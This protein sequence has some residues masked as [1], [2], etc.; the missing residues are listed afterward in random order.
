MK[1][2][3]LVSTFSRMKKYSPAIEA[4]V[5]RCWPEHP[6]MYF[7]SDCELPGI[8]R[9][10]QFA[11]ACW[12]E[13]LLQGLLTVRRKHPGLDYLFLMLDDHCPLRRRF[14]SIWKSREATIWR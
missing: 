5:D 7:I 1:T 2:L 9:Q 11:D 12:T 14:R 13:I 6:A 4:A 3:V 8:E 10:I